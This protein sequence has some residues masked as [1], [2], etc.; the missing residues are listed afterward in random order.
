[1]GILKSRGTNESASP[2]RRSISF[3]LVQDGNAVALQAGD[4]ISLHFSVEGISLPAEADRSFAVWALLPMAMEEGFNLHFNHPIDPKVAT[5]AEHLSQIWEMWM[6]SRYRSIRVSGQGN[7]SRPQRDRLPQVQLFSG[8][9]DSTFSIL[10]NRDAQNPGFVA[11]V[12]GI[13]KIKE[14]HVAGLAEKT[15]PIL[16]ALGYHRILIRTDAKR[17][18]N[19]LTH[20]FTL[21]SCLFLLGD[22]FERGTIAADWTHASDL[23]MHPWGNNHV[24]NTFFAGSDFFVESIG[25]ESGR[26]EKIAAIVRAGIDPHWLTFCRERKVIPSNCGMCN[27]CI[28]T[29]AMFLVATGSIP[30]IFVD[31][32]FDESLMRRLIEQRNERVELF[33]LYFYAKEHGALGKIPNLV[34][35]IDECRVQPVSDV[36]ET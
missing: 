29:K 5:N 30:D 15:D 17:Q 34:E 13:D 11:T 20:G 26:T 32:S 19:W 35:L 36:V 1:M 8:G 14:I 21:A 6:P 24:T 9:V 22:L 31:A 4:G 23:A 33:D 3:E 10:T 28:R 16:E 18:P 25:A 27:K 12:C 2:H 7:W